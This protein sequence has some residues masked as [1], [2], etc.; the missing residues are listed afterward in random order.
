[1]SVEVGFDKTTMALSVLTSTKHRH[2]VSQPVAARQGE[3]CAPRNQPSFD[4]AV[5][6]YS[7]VDEATEV[8]TMLIAAKTDL[9]N[10]S[11]LLQSLVEAEDN[12]R[13]SNHERSC[14]LLTALV[15]AKVDLNTHI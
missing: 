3:S 4:E 1:M 6:E 8:V 14:S 10:A 11:W 15:N 13:C 12:S 7:Q 2:Q 5:E 9:T